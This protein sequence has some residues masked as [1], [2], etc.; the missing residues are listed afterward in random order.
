MK[1]YLC[2]LRYILYLIF[3]SVFHV[4]ISV[5]QTDETDRRT[6]LQQLLNNIGKTVTTDKL[7]RELNSI[8]KKY[9]SNAYHSGIEMAEVL[10]IREI[11]D[12]ARRGYVDKMLVPYTILL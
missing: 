3:L 4:M 10:A 5:A 12:N 1:K 8:T 11:E 9:T 2:G 6:I 7:I